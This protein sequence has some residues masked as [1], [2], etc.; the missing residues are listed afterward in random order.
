MPGSPVFLVHDAGLSASKELIEPPVSW[1]STI[2][3]GDGLEARSL[4]YGSR[5]RRMSLAVIADLAG[6]LV[7]R[8]HVAAWIPENAARRWVS[9]NLTGSTRNSTA[10]RPMLIRGRI[11]ILL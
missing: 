2:R 8:N 11:R 10:V 5:A 9:S 6:R 1:M 7:A 4:G 3:S